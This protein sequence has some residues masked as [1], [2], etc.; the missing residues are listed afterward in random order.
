MGHKK[1]G[2]KVLYDISP[3]ADFSNWYLSILFA[4]VWGMYRTWLFGPFSHHRIP[5]ATFCCH[6]F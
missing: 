4:F 5:S 6:V 2:S 3:P 1:V